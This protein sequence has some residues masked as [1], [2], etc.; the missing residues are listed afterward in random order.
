MQFASD[1]SFVHKVYISEKA[2]G[3]VI[4]SYL[5]GQTAIFINNTAN[6]PNK[7]CLNNGMQSYCAPLPMG[8]DVDDYTNINTSGFFFISSL[9]EKPEEVTRIWAEVNLL[10]DENL[11]PIPELAELVRTTVPVEFEWSSGNPNRYISTEREYI[12]N[13]VDQWPRYRMDFTDSFPNL[14]TNISNLIGTPI[15]NGTK[16]VTQA[17]DSAESVLQSLIDP[18]K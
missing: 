12:L 18:Y 15:L 13:Y 8:P 16:S 11:K 14:T 2:V 4:P 6:A 10:W 7:L 3:G 5:N 1:L 9:C 17:I